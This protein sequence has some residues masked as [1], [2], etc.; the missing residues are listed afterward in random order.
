MGPIATVQRPHRRRQEVILSGDAL[1]QVQVAEAALECRQPLGLLGRAAQLLKVENRPE[2][3]IGLVPG[4]LG[5]RI[6]LWIG[7][8][9]K[10]LGGRVIRRLGAVDQRA[11]QIGIGGSLRA[12]DDAER[13]LVRA[14]AR[15]E[16]VVQLGSGTAHPAGLI[17]DHQRR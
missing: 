6:I 3:G 16:R 5:P 8:P 15:L 9:Q 13:V 4:R 17:V 1:V 7:R 2:P 10:Q 12:D 14:H 11:E